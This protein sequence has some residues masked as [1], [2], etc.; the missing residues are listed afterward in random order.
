[1]AEATPVMSSD[2][3]LKGI[4]FLALGVVIF[5]VQDV[6]VKDL[7]GL[8]PVHEMLFVRSVVG[9]FPLAAVIATTAGLGGFRVQRA[10]ILRGLVHFFSYS[11]YYLALSALPLAET[12]TLYYTNPLIITA[13]S[14]P[15]LGETVGWRR[16]SAV[17]VGFVGVVVVLQPGVTAIQ[18]AMLLALL[19][20]CF[21]GVSMLITRRN[22]KKV[23]AISFAI[24]SMVILA[25]CA[26]LSGL[27]IGDGRFDTLDDGS[28][29]FLLRAWVVPNW[30]DFL[31][32]GSCGLIAAVAFYLLSQAYRVAPASVVT[33]FEYSS[34]PMAVLFGYLF[35]GDLPGPATWIGLALIVGAGL[36]IVHRETVQ[37]RRIV[38]GWPPMRPRL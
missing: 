27:A 36:Y 6:I 19:S 8:Y 2:N 3:T 16:W 24:H 32:L 31:L 12:V 37:G 22:A 17:G 4:S 34:L 1:M 28:A 38:R 10:A 21:Y 30:H 26:G 5:T 33:P 15:F 20:A 29:Q 25:L 7:S 35:F 13:L 23:S 9:F 11:V 14:V 18:P